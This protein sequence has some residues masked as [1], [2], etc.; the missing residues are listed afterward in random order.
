M[1][2]HIVMWTLKE[3]AEGASKAENIIKIREQLEAL[4]GVVPG[5]LNVE[6]GENFTDSPAAADLV[7]YSEIESRE[8]LPVYQ[9]HPEHVKVAQFIGAVTSAR[10]V[11]DYE[12]I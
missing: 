8:A 3:Q 12:S 1:I 7:L 10:Q 11:V 4:V 6:V 2:K 9:Q 5:L